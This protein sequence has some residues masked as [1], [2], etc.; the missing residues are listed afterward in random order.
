MNLLAIALVVTTPALPATKVDFRLGGQPLIQQTSSTLGSAGT[1]L[2]LAPDAATTG[3][4]ATNGQ[5]EE[6]SG[7]AD[8]GEVQP[9][10]AKPHFLL[11]HGFGRG[12]PLAFAVRQVVPPRVQV[13]YG[14]GVDQQ[15]AVTWSGGK[16][17]DQVLRTA[18]GPLGLR[19]VVSHMAVKIVE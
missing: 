19:V 7:E 1:P 15:Q 9:A 17:W 14:Q 12:V 3:G 13:S 4:S 10:V 2:P 16:P 6:G 5:D 18:V 11:A 8:G